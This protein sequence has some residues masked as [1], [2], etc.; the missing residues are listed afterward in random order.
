MLQFPFLVFL[1]FALPKV[2][3][4]VPVVVTASSVSPAPVGTMI[5]W[6]ANPSGD[7]NGIWYRFRV[8]RVGGDYRTIRDYSPIADLDW[9]A[10]ETE[11]TYEI[12]ASARN[13]ETGETSQRS[14]LF[15]F[16]SRASNGPVVN[17]TEHPLV[18]LY[19]APPCPAGARMR[20]E[21]QGE[22]EPLRT[23]ER[24]CDGIHSMN[25]YL[26]GVRG[27]T[28]H[29][30]R[31]VITAAGKI[32]AGPPVEFTSGEAPT[33]LV[34]YSLLNPP[35]SVT[36]GFLLQSPISAPALATDLHGNIVWY[37]TGRLSFVTRPDH[38]SFF[39][40]VQ[41]E[42]DQ[43]EQIVREFD[44]AGMTLR[45]TNAARINEQLKALGHQSIGGFHH[46]ARRLDDGR[47]LVLA[48]TERILSEVQGP[49]PVHIVGD[50][51]LVLDS[52]LQVVWVWD[53]FDHMDVRRKALLNETC[54]GNS[55][56]AR[57][58]LGENGNDWLHSNSA[59][60]TPD[61]DLLLSIRH[62]DWV[63]KINYDRGT[64][65]GSIVWRLGRDGDFG[66]ISDDPYPWFS[67]QHDAQFI[68]NS[69]IIL[70]DNGNTHVVTNPAAHSR[71]QV[72]RLDEV[73]R[74]AH[75][76]VNVDLGGYSRALGSA[77]KL[78]NGAYHFDAGWLPDS[79]AVSMEMDE[80][81]EIT[82]AIRADS[83]QYRTFRLQDMYTPE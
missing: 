79:S 25:F 17:P 43:S 45:E 72:I 30:A 14:E 76:E 6:D 34:E 29:T 28:R 12:E 53:S 16:V 19:S 18:F 23:P 35:D 83:P 27:E 77:Q 11:G 20:V 42:G 48:S 69:R 55:G 68:D 24:D 47:I 70:F 1:F 82:Y 26:A 4:E 10:S 66:F 40:I 22:S 78:P 15:Q 80:S 2:R 9:T 60:Q 44:L 57:Q 51:I 67:H 71:G 7:S 65:D 13:L 59:Q 38:G 36:Y 62:Q 46:E 73:N 41:S 31:Q 50:T 61:G 74:L 64:G 3:A 21:F 52:N 58:Y 37:Y 54:G 49:G 75:L 33:N 63:I 8:R 32:E 39:G 5:H 81:G 56:C